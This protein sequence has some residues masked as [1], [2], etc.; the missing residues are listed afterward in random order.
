MAQLRPLLPFSTDAYFLELRDGRH[1]PSAKAT[2]VHTPTRTPIVEDPTVVPTEAPVDER[3]LQ[4][5]L[6]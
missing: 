1:Q 2:P 4:K 6:K 3:L 5:R